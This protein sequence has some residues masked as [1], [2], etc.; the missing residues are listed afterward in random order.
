MI[1]GNSHPMD[2]MR[3]ICSAIG[4]L[5]PESL[6]SY[7]PKEISIRLVAVFGPALLYWHHYHQTGIRINSYTGPKDTIAM[8]FMKLLNNNP[9]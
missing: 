1:P 8:N 9:N 4:N 7:G 2:V 3:T 6:P 5:E